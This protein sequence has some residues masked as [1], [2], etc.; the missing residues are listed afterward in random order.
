MNWLGWALVAVAG[1]GTAYQLL[2]AVLTGRSASADAALG[3]TPAV[4]ILKPL[5][6]AEPRLV[7][8]LASFVTQ[9]YRGAVQIVCGVADA[10]DPA[11]AAVAALR[12]LYPKAD[13]ALVVDP[14]RH[15]G[16]AKVSN[17]VNMMGA[18]K[19]DVLVLSDSDMA[20]EADYLARIV[21]ALGEPAPAPPATATCHPGERR[22]P[23]SPSAVND[24]ELGP[25]VRGDDK[26][27]NSFPEPT[28]GAVTVLYH[29]RGDAGP[30]STLA[31]M[32]ISHG[33]LPSVLVGMRLGLATPCMGSTIALSR[34]T[35][36]RI[37][38]FAAFA[39][40]LA[41]DYAIGA[42]VRS[43]G[44]SVAVPAF[45]IGHACADSSFTALA[46]HE[47]RWNAT[48]RRLSPAGFA[49][50]GWLNPVPVALLA[51]LVGGFAPPTLAVMA[52]ALLS[53]VAVA[54][55]VDRFT[56]VPP[57]PL[58]MMPARDILSFGLFLAS[59]L[60]QSVDWR[61]ATLNVA[62]NG[63]IIGE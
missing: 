28:P 61:G 42:A 53:R 15:G 40:D 62:R 44:S 12:E 31:A 34:A 16:N 41:D 25:G 49:V 4:T 21:G 8:N 38:G 10:G 58:W 37:G 47:L 60:V 18:A 6:G 48:I 26:P 19:H 43:L 33:F 55:R 14:A 27:E 1:A 23:A 24:R 54:V 35:L 59:F 63:R 56:G 3:D 5:H 50:G 22:D 20:V 9:N 2:S 51:C 30:W 32:A 7:E 46:R 29:G 52:A 13:I 36:D 57:G 17:L 39:D 11:V 45:T